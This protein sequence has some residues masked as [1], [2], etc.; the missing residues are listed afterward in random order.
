VFFSLL[1]SR[2][3]AAQSRVPRD[4]GDV[5]QVWGSLAL[6]PG[7]AGGNQRVAG[8]LALWVTHDQLA[9]WVR[10]AGT[11]RLL[12]PGDLGDFSVL[13]GIHPRSESHV[14]FIAG[15]GLGMS[16]GHA[17]DGAVLERKPVLAGGAHFNVNYRVIGVAIDAFGAAGNARSY[18]GIG[19]GLALGVFR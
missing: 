9:V 8:D 14:D 11:S 15:V 10:D 4:S 2:G 6:G 12:E 16:L 5:W 19:V 3:V 13:A 17:N 18:Y 1:A 7:N